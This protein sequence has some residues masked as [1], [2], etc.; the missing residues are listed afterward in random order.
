MKRFEICCELARCG[1]NFKNRVEI[2]K[3]KI[4]SFFFACH[5]GFGIGCM[6]AFSHVTQGI[7]TRENLKKVLHFPQ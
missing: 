7:F 1:L 2:L 4:S 5:G 6:F 3:G